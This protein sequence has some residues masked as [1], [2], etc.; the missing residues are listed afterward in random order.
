MH[1]QC[2]HS[3]FSPNL[4]Y[5]LRFFIFFPIKM[6]RVPYK[7]RCKKE[8]TRKKKNY[9]PA[10]RERERHCQNCV[11]YF[12]TGL[13]ALQ[14]QLQ[15][16]HTLHLVITAL[17]LDQMFYAHLYDTS[18]FVLCIQLV[19]CANDVNEYGKQYNLNKIC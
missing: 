12:C 18:V 13:L 11:D 14:L 1:I 2:I 10:E 17:D 9:H 3:H 8:H 16:Q 15:Q 7:T 5:F 6:H 4:W 19:D